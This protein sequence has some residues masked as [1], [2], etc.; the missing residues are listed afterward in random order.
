VTNKQTPPN[1][2][3][4]KTDHDRNAEAAVETVDNGTASANGLDDQLAAALKEAQVNL[5]GW[6]R[7]LAEFQNYKRRTERDLKD[8][9]Q[10]ASLDVLKNLLPIIDDF[11][12]AMSNVPESIQGQ[13]WLEGIT[14]IQR[15]FN[16]L[17]EDNNVQSIDPVGDVFDPNLH[18]AIGHE[19]A[20]GIESGHVTTTLQRGYVSGDRV[21]RPAI[22][23][24]AE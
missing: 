1:S 15:K 21:L 6:Q 12:R 11:E 20:E 2:D 23:K 16:K 14:L 4:N 5:E 9:Y 17:L 22:V 13:S 19:E 3:G 10:N 8:S 7:T 24:V 18:Q